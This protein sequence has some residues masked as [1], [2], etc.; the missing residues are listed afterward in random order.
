MQP[1]HDELRRACDAG[2]LSIDAADTFY[3]GFH[4]SLE[5]M[6][7][8]YADDTPCTCSDEGRHGHQPECRWIKT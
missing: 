3:A 5:A 7:Y 8:R 1:S 2:F 4:S 6:G